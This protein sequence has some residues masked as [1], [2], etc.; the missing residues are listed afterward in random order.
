MLHTDPIAVLPVAVVAELLSLC[1]PRTVLSLRVAG[2][3][4]TA[5]QA[6]TSFMFRTVTVTGTAACLGGRQAGRQ[7]EHAVYVST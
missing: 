4:G 3:L 5:Q 6:V 2:S 1:C 7:A